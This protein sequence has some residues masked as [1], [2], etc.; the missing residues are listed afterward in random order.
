VVG[1]KIGLERV[2]SEKARFVR[3]LD[4]CDNNVQKTY[5][6]MLTHNISMK[7]FVWVSLIQTLSLCILFLNLDIIMGKVINRSKQKCIH[8]NT[9]AINMKQTTKIKLSCKTLNKMSSIL[10]YPIHTNTSCI[11]A[12][13]CLLTKPFI[14]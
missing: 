3:F 9:L 12:L 2:N 8:I 5:R 7:L 10:L 6:T 4:V 14:S 13:L 1:R 11:T